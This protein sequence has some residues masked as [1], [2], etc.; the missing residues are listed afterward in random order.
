MCKVFFSVLFTCALRTAFVTRFTHKIYLNGW[1]ARQRIKCQCM[2][3]Q[4]SSLT[5]PQPQCLSRYLFLSLSQERSGNNRFDHQNLTLQ[6]KLD[7]EFELVFVVAY[8]RIL[9][10]AYVDKFLSDVQ[11]AFRDKY[12]NVLAL[13][14]AGSGTDDACR[15]YHTQ[16]DFGAELRDL[17]RE[18]EEW[19]RAQARQPKQMRTFND[20]AKSKKTVGSMIER[21]NGED[22]SDGKAIVGGKKSVRIV[23]E[24]PVLEDAPKGIDEDTLLANRRKLAEKLTGKKGVK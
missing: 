5:K 6:Y 2:R 13:G 1:P 17:L 15:C 18:A 20:S 16:F 24:E 23:E 10:L 4:R 3:K 8:Q 11:L 7:N 14:S 12:K 9:Q 21:R 22:W 19:Q